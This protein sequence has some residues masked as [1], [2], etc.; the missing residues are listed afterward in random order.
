VAERV[1]LPGDPVAHIAEQNFV[2]RLRVPGRHADF[3]KAGDPLRVDAEE[4]GE[5]DA[6]F[7]TIKLV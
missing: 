2:L 7:G 4:L 6:R 1:V 3:L 5:S